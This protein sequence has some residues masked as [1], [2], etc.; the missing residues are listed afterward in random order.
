[1]GPLLN[2]FEYTGKDIVRQGKFE[3]VKFELVIAWSKQGNLS[4]SSFAFEGIEGWRHWASFSG[5]TP[6]GEPLSYCLR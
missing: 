2:L 3:L 4:L 5:L 1:M 6:K